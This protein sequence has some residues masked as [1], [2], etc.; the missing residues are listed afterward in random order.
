[1]TSDDDDE[2]ALIF[3]PVTFPADMLEDD[4]AELLQQLSNDLGIPDFM[5]DASIGS[6]SNDGSVGS[7]GVNGVSVGQ[8]STDLL[9]DQLMQE[10]PSLFN[11]II[12]HDGKKLIIFL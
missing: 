2:Y 1:M 9:C 10:D 7:S 8:T 4:P 5:D 3:V 12:Q 6:A 11:E